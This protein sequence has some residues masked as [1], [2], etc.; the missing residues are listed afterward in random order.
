MSDGGGGILLTPLAGY[1]DG[2][3]SKSTA[4][5]PNFIPTN[6]MSGKTIFGLTGTA[7]QGKRYAAG[8]ASTHTSVIFTRIDGTLQNMAKLDVTGLN[9]TPRA[10]IIYDQNGYFCTALQTDA[11]VYSG[12][13][14]FLASG[15][16]M[17]LIS[18]ASVF[19]GG[20]SLPVSQWDILY[21]WYAFE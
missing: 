3:T 19:A 21:Y 15:T 1:Y 8:T 10:V 7:I 5:D 4:W 9:F 20:F 17:L 16:Y 11:P 6:I 12:N 2:S 14:V 18:P 13:Q